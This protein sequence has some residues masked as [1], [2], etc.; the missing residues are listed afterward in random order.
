MQKLKG[1]RRFFWRY[2]F[3]KVLRTNTR[4]RSCIGLESVQLMGLYCSINSALDLTVLSKFILNLHYRGIKTKNFILLSKEYLEEVKGKSLELGIDESISYIKSTDLNYIR[5]P[6]GEVKLKFNSFC[7]EE[8]DILL[9]LNLHYDEFAYLLCAK[10]IAKFKL[11]RDGEYARDVNDFSLH[12]EEGIG[13]EV[14]N[15]LLL[16]H[17]EK[18]KF[19]T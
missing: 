18:F 11:G 9:N 6:K 1:L 7:T 17:L 15:K 2:Y 4:I 14:F 5:L 3:Y 12:L 10:S 19:T 16:E 8:F 13:Q